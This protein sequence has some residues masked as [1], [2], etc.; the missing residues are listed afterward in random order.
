MH[1][2][3]PLMTPKIGFLSFPD[4]YVSYIRM[5][6]SN[7]KAPKT[8]HITIPSQTPKS[9]EDTYRKATSKR[10]KKKWRDEAGGGGFIVQERR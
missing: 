1:Q 4:I 7:K 6:D 5:M 3:D 2:A 9:H 8:T 10:K